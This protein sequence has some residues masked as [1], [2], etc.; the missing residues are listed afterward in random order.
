[1]YPFWHI[2]FWCTSLRFCT[3]CL[4]LCLSFH[5]VCLCFDIYVSV[6]HLNVVYFMRYVSQWWYYSYVCVSCCM[7]YV[8][9]LISDVVSLLTS[10]SFDGVC[11]PVVTHCIFQFWGSDCLSFYVGSVSNSLSFVVV[12]IL[13]LVLSLSFDNECASVLYGR[14]CEHPC[15]R[16]MNVMV[17]LYVAGI[18]NILPIVCVPHCTKTWETSRNDF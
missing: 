6:F 2:Q 16:C 5:V 10:H 12:C 18:P 7:V 3:V 11:V 15:F 4:S 1:M 8:L 14:C 17:F 9:V 13:V